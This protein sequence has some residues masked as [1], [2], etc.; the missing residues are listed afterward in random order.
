MN[1]LCGVNVLDAQ[2]ELVEK[3]LHMQLGEELRREEDLAQVG[4][5]EFKNN[6]ESVLRSKET[7]GVRASEVDSRDVKVLATA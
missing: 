2:T 1:N 3:E 7:P 4:L 6:P 5:N